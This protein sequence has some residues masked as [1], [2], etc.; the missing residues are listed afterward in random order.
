MTK[1]TFTQEEMDIIRQNPY[2]VSVSSTKISYSLEFKKFAMKHSKEGMK[3]TE[4]FQKA[5]FDTE[6]LGK[7]R[8]YAAIKKIK[9]E[10]A[11]PNGL[12][13]PWGKSK[14]Q[15]LAEF[16]EEDFSK[17]QTQKAIQ[18][19]QKKILHLEQQIEF[20]KKIQLPKE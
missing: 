10:A 4:I 14:E 18:D 3:S 16:A 15:R 2:V 9:K 19:L 8:M 6:M 17:K 11:S 20:L 1:Q 12:H 7:S 13:E 5:G